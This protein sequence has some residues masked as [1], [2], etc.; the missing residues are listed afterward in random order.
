MRLI[1]MLLDLFN[2]KAR[3]AKRRRA[4]YDCLREAIF[5]QHQAGIGALNLNSLKQVFDLTD[6]TA[7]KLPMYRIG[8]NAKSEPMIIWDSKM[9]TEEIGPQLTEVTN[10]SEESS[11][12]NIS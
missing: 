5:K 4:S 11:V 9:M 2:P 10:G 8:I 1:R 7:F 6:L 12:E 3:E